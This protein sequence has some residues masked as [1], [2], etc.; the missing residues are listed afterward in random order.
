LD[1]LAV[2][3]AAF[4]TVLA[5]AGFARLLVLITLDFHCLLPLAMAVMLRPEAA[6]V[7]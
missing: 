3:L 6:L 1:A 5:F 7:L 2:F 4:L